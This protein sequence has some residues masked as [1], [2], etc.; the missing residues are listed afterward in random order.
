M[1]ATFRSLSTEPSGHVK[2]KSFIRQGGPLILIHGKP[3]F[4][5]K[6]LDIFPD[7]AI[8]FLNLA[9]TCINDT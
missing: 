4:S 6:L 9:A 3:G 8:V 1:D 2:G 5:F 7:S